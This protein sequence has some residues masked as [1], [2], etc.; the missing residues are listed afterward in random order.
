MSWEW[1]ACL[2]KE[3]QRIWRRKFTVSHLRH[4]CRCK[5]Y[6]H[7]L[8]VQYISWLYLANRYFGLLQFA[9]VIPLLTDAFSATECPKIFRWQP[10]GAM[11]TTLICQ[12]ILGA[13]VFVVSQITLL[14][15]G[16]PL[17]ISRN[18]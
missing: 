6:A 2:P 7:D 9:L 8:V 12:F 1:L 11:I 13:R 16:Y 17:I 10:V 18:V 3:V 14:N 4:Q 5:K 15:V